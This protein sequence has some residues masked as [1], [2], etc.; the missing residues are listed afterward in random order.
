MKPIRPSPPPS[1][2][3][4]ATANTNARDQE[5]R[6]RPAPPSFLDRHSITRHSCAS[7]PQNHNRSSLFQRRA[8]LS[9]PVHPLSGYCSPRPGEFGSWFQASLDR[10]SYPFL[11]CRKGGI[12]KP[13]RLSPP[14]SVGF[15]RTG[16]TTPRDKEL[17]PT[18][19]STSIDVYPLPRLEPRQQ[20]SMPTYRH[21]VEPC[22]SR[23]ASG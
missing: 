13:I 9:Y 19:R 12:M 8:R 18:R 1:E 3:S 16:T 2:K 10:I 7:I 17:L 14:P 20:A 21:R 23:Q 15:W 4:C 6:H 11:G 5:P 22:L